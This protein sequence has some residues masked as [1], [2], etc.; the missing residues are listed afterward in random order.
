MPRWRSSARRLFESE[1]Q[2]MNGFRLL[3]SVFVLAAGCIS[4]IALPPSTPV[5]VFLPLGLTVGWIASRLLRPV[6]V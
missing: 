3:L 6:F 2:T 5:V 4:P 1:R